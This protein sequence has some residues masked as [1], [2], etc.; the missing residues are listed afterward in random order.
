[1]ALDAN[2]DWTLVLERAGMLAIFTAVCGLLAA[3]AFRS[4]QRA[5]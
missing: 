4:Y 5:I 2:T 1:V 3:R